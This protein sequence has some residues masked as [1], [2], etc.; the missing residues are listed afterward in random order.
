MDFHEIFSTGPTWNREHPGQFHA[1][2]DC[3]AFLKLG[4][5]EVCALR[6]LLGGLLID[7]IQWSDNIENN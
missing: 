1:L 3:F 4:A 2:P 5:V 6:V 7:H